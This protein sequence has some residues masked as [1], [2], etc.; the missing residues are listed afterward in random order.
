MTII[1]FL[2]EIIAYALIWGAVEYK[3]PNKYVQPLFS[4]GFFIQVILIAIGIY[5]IQ[6]INTWFIT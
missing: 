1:K 6:N 5:I 4:K 2:I 3:R